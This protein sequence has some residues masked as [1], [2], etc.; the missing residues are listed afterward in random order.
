MSLIA[1]LISLVLE[2]S[3]TPLREYRQFGWFDRYTDKVKKWCDDRG[4]QGP[5]VVL[6]V[7]A[8]PI[9]A[10]ILVNTILDGVLLGLLS[11]LF[12][13]A[14]L[15]FCLGPQDTEQQVEGFLT[16]WDSEDEDEAKAAAKELLGET[17]PEALSELQQQLVERILIVGSERI[18]S[19]L[20]WFTVFAMLGSGPL[21]V[22]IYRLGCHLQQRLGQQTDAFATSINRLYAILGWVPAHLVAL[23]F[24]MA[25][26][27]VDMIHFW[28]E[29]SSSWRDDWQQAASLAV[30]T[31]GLGALQMST[32]VSEEE[33]SSEDVPQHVRAAMGLVLRSIVILVVLIAV[34]TLTVF[35]N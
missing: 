5:T 21:G 4:W 2:R 14:V 6:L 28:R 16:A 15:F 12:T 22:V 30:I 20:I 10:V 7:I 18:L 35:G 17:P 11:L 26:S 13:T 24:A 31:G 25:G 32:P 27:F 29:R 3:F 9:L 19:P 8:G 34:I 1:I 33:I 23:L